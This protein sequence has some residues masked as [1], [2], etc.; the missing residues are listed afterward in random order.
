MI[1]T[2]EKENG[3]L[4]FTFSK[5][6]YKIYFIVSQECVDDIKNTYGL[7]LTV[8]AKI[9]SEKY[10]LWL[11]RCNEHY[12]IYQLVFSLELEG[13][14]TNTLKVTPQFQSIDE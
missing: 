3:D 11:E 4:K 7:D 6:Y 13:H 9:A 8:Y 2:S 14:L 5:G 10:I 12:T 1:V